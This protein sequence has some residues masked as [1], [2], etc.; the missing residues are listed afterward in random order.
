MEGHISTSLTH[1][2]KISYRLAEPSSNADIQKALEKLPHAEDV[3]ARWESL[4]QHLESHVPN[5][6]KV[7]M[8]IWPLRSGP[9]LKVD[10]DKET[11]ID[12]PAQAIALL[13]RQYRPPYVVPEE[14]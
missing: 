8:K 13:R 5:E 4:R 12:A 11:F 14:V 9:Q 1:L 3:V 10:S 7:G 2:G 6:A